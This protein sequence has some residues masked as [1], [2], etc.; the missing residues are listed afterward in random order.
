MVRSG[1]C[2][3]GP[4]GAAISPGIGR[5]ASPKMRLFVPPVGAGYLMSWSP[6]AVV[7]GTVVP[8]GTIGPAVT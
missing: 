5:A 7:P 4:Q 6:I 3:S 8:P 1:S 2:L